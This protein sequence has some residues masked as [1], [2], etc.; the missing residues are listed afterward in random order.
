M[1][2]F[3]IQREVE[4]CAPVAILNALQWQKRPKPTL[5]EL[6]KALR[7]SN[8]GVKFRDFRRHCRAI[9]FPRLIAS[10]NQLELAMRH[11]DGAILGFHLVLDNNRQSGH[12]VFIPKAND[13]A[14]YCTN[15]DGSHR[16][17]PKLYLPLLN[18]DKAFLFVVP[19]M[20]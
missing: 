9:G 12:V 11:E 20:Q 17:I 18:W 13:R 6:K 16:W 8:G 19:R 14:Y 10:P 5:Q 4:G 3:S 1:P 15:F 7:L 2:K